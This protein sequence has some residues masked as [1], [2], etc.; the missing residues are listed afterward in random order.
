MGIVRWAPPEA[1]SSNIAGT[2]LNALGAN[3]ESPFIPY[4]NSLNRN[5]YAAVTVR[6]GSINPGAGGSIT[7]S[8]YAGDGTDT[9]D[10]LGSAIESYS[11]QLTSNSSSKVAIFQM[12]RLSPFLCYF[13]VSV[14]VGTAALNNQFYVRP[15]NN[16]LI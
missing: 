15:Y 7:L 16:E 3:A 12:V 5:L 9:P 14:N 8:V 11:S 10:R 2:A 13:T 1:R 6:L 4:D